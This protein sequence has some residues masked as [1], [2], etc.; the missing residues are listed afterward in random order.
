[1]SEAKHTPGPW[2]WF[3]NAKF[4]GF[5]LATTHS[6]RRY[7]MDFVRMGMQGAQPRFQIDGLMEDARDLCSFEVSNAIGIKEGE[8]D[9]RTYRYDIDGINHPDAR[10]IAAAPELLE[11]L[12]AIIQREND[13]NRWG[14]GTLIG[15]SVADNARRA[16]AKATGQ[17]Q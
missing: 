13:F 7:V 10:L 16:I 14:Q 9:G 1:M 2:A 6:G 15:D 4:G 12:Q 8:S 5:Y 3:G 11:A 17:E